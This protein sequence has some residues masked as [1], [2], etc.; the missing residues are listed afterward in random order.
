MIR[1]SSQLA[2]SHTLQHLNSL[3]DLGLFRSPFRDH[4]QQVR[5]P[6]S[7]NDYP[8]LGN[9]FRVEIHEILRLFP[10]AR[11]FSYGTAA[12]PACAPSGDELPITCL[13]RHAFRKS[14]SILDSGLERCWAAVYSAL[15]SS[16]INSGWQAKYSGS[17]HVPEGRT[18]PMA[19]AALSHLQH[20]NSAPDPEM[21]PPQF[22]W[23]QRG[24]RRST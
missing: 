21:V 16:T 15:S 19:G 2:G 22:A 17:F 9:N 24:L 3:I 14:F 20:L 8:T 13:A 7:Q 12:R 6:A 10:L 11:S 18:A 4:R 1:Y 23:F 5:Y